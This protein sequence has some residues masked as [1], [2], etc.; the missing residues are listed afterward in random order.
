M[1]KLD[2]NNLAAPQMLRA[3]SLRSTSAALFRQIREE[4][5][6]QARQTDPRRNVKREKTSHHV[7]KIRENTV[8]GRDVEREQ[9]RIAS[10]KSA[11]CAVVNLALELV[12]V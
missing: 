7:E 6:V 3:S 11:I 10:L 12:E 1:H 8:G 4:A 2:S 9:D 5:R